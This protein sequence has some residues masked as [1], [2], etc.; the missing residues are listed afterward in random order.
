MYEIEYIDRILI[1]LL[2]YNY[3]FKNF[4]ALQVYQITL[5]YTSTIY[6]S[7]RFIDKNICS[8]NRTIVLQCR[9]FII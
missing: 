1:L 7:F 9:F 3:V 2:N 4:F 8:I 5:Q 6:L